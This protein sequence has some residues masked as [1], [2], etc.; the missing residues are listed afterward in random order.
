MGGDEF[1]V[2]ISD[3]ST[4]ETI[5]EVAQRIVLAIEK[6]FILQNAERRISASLGIAI[7]PEDGETLDTLIKH[8]DMAMYEVKK[9]G[10][11]NYLYY[12]PSVK[13]NGLEQ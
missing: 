7:Y 1:A 9:M 2:L 8:A 13:S 12:Q 11:N 6:T 3:V 5:D 4:K 10:R